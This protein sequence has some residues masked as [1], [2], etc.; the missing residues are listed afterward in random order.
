M[1]AHTLTHKRA[2]VKYEAA[3]RLIEIDGHM[4]GGT[5]PCPTCQ[6]VSKVLGRPFGCEASRA[7]ATTE[8]ES[9]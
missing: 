9:K 8:G 1:N 7:K 5:R 2:V 6:K 4:Y 3:L